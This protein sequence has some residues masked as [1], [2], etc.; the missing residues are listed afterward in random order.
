MAID[1][2]TLRVNAVINNQDRLP[3]D[4]VFGLI[5]DPTFNLSDALRNQDNSALAGKVHNLATIPTG[6]L[7]GMLVA[8]D[9]S[10]DL[11]VADG[12]NVAF[13]IFGMDL[14]WDYFQ[15]PGVQ[16]ITTYGPGKADGFPVHYNGGRAIL[17]RY[18]ILSETG[19]ALT[20]ASGDLLYRSA[21]GMITK[22]NTVDPTVLGQVLCV[23]QDGRLDC[24]FV[25]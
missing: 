6:P 25:L 18:M 9:N 21:T 5:I 4:V 3:F 2:S 12:R 20:Y 19:A 24:K 8:L 14:R 13:G 11:V 17:D 15:T 23:Y 7:A 10:G 22:D 1:P 16:A